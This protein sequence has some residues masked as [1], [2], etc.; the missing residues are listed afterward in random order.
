M[1]D[2]FNTNSNK[3]NFNINAVSG[4]LRKSHPK[5]KTCVTS[6]SENNMMFD[7]DNP[8]RVIKKEQYEN[9]YATYDVIK[10]IV[11]LQTM[12]VGDGKALVEY[13]LLEDFGD[14]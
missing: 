12:L 11:V 1:L 6:L 8:R 14:E 2:N 9:S 4:T 7:S 13:V 5:S 3:F 10:S